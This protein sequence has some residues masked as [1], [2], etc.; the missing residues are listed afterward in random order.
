VTYGIKGVVSSP[1]EGANTSGT[2]GFLTGLSKGI[3]G[4]VI[5]PISGVIDLT[6]KTAEGIKNTTRLFDVPVN[7]LS[8]QR[9]RLPRIF[10]EQSQFFK[11]YCQLHSEVVLFLQFE[12][13]VKF[14]EL[15]V[16]E[17]I[18]VNH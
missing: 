11:S 17:C 13:S 8:Q 2:K 16:Y 15:L 4:L 18:E 6:S 5:K 14:G 10:Y 12:K 7:D 3:A 9:S 1:L